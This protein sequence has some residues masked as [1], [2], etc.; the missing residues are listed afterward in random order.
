MHRS[1]KFNELDSGEVKSLSLDETDLW[2]G[3]CYCGTNLFFLVLLLRW[4]L[5]SLVAFL[6]RRRR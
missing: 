3:C 2:V 4:W 6:R 1:A 5:L